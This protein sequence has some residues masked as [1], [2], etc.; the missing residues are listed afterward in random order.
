[1]TRLLHPDVAAWLLRE[2][3]E[4]TTAQEA[5]VPLILEGRSVLL[6]SPTGTGKTLAGFLGVI[7]RLYREHEAGTLP[8]LGIRAVYVSPSAP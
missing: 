2:L 7:D 3:G 5:C 1:M 6:S 4:P 8:S